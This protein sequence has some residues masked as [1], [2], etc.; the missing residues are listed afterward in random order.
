MPAAAELI[1]LKG[2]PCILSLIHDI[3][4]R[5][6]WRRPCGRAKNASS[7]LPVRPTTRSGIG[8]VEQSGLV[9]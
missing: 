3:T 7:S 4:D 8:P 1:E 6:R 5:K 9:E 2:Q